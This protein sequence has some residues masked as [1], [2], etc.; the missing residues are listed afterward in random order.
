M[1]SEN[2][3]GMIDS[4][5]NSTNTH[6]LADCWSV[7]ALFLIPI[8]GG[9]P[10]GVLLA[11]SKGLHWGMTALIYLVSDIILAMI[12][13]PLMLG[14]IHLGRKST[15]LTKV[16]ASMKASVK[17][18]SANYGTDLG[19]MALILLAFGAD[20]MTGRSAAVAAGYGFVWGWTFA[21]AGDMIFFTLLM[22]S[23][24]WLNG[25]L[26]D[27][28][29]TTVIILAVMFIVPALIRKWRASRVPAS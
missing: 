16:L 9:I 4:V 17:K 25:I 26:G 12:F 20:P 29:W 21:I 8:G 6:F 5:T 27:G 28:T 14:V 2:D 3:I 13:E 10:G 7:L 18:T 11:K 1:G 19:P 15:Q 23:T 22:A 24:L